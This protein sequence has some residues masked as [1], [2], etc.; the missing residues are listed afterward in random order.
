MTEVKGSFSA[1]DFLSLLT[2]RTMGELGALEEVVGE[3]EKV[4]RGGLK[5][6][7]L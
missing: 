1:H 7:P 4:R 2:F 6:A 3:K 5:E